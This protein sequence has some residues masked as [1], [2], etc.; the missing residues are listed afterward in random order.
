[1]KKTSI[2]YNLLGVVLCGLATPAAADFCG[3]NYNDCCEWSLLDGKVTV[4]ADWLYWKVE[5]DGLTPGGISVRSSSE[6]PLVIDSS[7]VR[8]NYKYDN[9]F[10]VNLGYELPGDSWDMN[11][12]YTYM[13]SHAKTTT[14][15]AASDFEVF[16]VDLNE[17]LEK[18]FNTF[19]SK[20]NLTL[21]N[22]DL[23]IGRTVSFGESLK[24]RPHIGF[25][26]SWFDQKFRSLATSSFPDIPEVTGLATSIKEK[27]QGYGVEG[28]L[29]ADYKLGGGLSIVGHVGGSILY[30]KYKV[31]GVAESGIFLIEDE[32]IVAENISFVSDTIRAGTPTVDYFIGL[33]YAD[34]FCDMFVK[35]HIG[36]EQ[37]VMFDTNR[38]LVGTNGN[39]TTQG[40]TLGLEVGF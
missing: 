4:G 11:V 33:Q 7:I 21:N 20:W 13:P 15:I 25:R 26:A 5:Q 23:D 32:S 18:G 38:L 30:S 8:P 2:I 17:D 27:F 35:A 16:A 3:Q 22:I 6:E 14:F 19:A 36:W 24:V 9:G 40:L 10:R 29:W 28:G 1:M 31:S 39:L 12:C 37:H 34:C